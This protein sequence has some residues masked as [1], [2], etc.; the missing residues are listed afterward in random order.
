[1]SRAGCSN[2]DRK[3]G[4]FAAI[5]AG[6]ALPSDACVRPPDAACFEPSHHGI[7]RDRISALQGILAIAPTALPWP[8]PGGVR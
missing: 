3:S 5:P 6:V 2:T 7:R 4:R 8:L 1:M